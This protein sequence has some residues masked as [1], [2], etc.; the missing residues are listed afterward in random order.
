MNGD[1]DV[2]NGLVDTVRKGKSGTNGES[3]IKM[4]ALSCVKWIGGERLLCNMG[5][6]AW[7]SL[8]DLEG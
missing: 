5:S 6:P 7:C 1:I 2:E 8:D 3:S 4:Y